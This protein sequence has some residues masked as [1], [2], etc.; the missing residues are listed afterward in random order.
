MVHSNKE[1]IHDGEE[2][3]EES[4]LKAVC[5]FS[6]DL[7]E[8]MIRNNHHFIQRSTPSP[9]PLTSQRPLALPQ[10]DTTGPQTL[11]A[12]CCHHQVC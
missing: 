8:G 2:E 9:P 11:H 6:G 4:H 3:E 10:V 5:S 1:E 12:L 7:R